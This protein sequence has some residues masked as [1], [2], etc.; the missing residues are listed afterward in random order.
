MPA[1]IRAKKNEASSGLPSSTEAEPLTGK[2][3][4]FSHKERLLEQPITSQISGSQ[5]A[6]LTS[7]F[8]RTSR[9]KRKTMKAIVRND[10]M[11]GG[12]WRPM[13]SLN[14]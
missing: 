14:R 10:A 1:T 6:P 5:S 12:I 2:P 9:L 13:T 3:K 4:V 8:P 11:I 7:G